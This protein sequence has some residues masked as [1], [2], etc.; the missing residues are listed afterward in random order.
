MLPSSVIV[1]VP[2]DDTG[3]NICD[4]NVFVAIVDTGLGGA[5]GGVSIPLIG[6]AVGGLLDTLVVGGTS[7]LATLSTYQ[8]YNEIYTIPYL[9]L[10]SISSSFCFL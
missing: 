3:V 8:L 10:C 4:G 6:G 5:V 1:G 7:S 2:I 9:P